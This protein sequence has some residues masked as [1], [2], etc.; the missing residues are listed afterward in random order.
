MAED[1]GIPQENEKEL[2]DSLEG[3]F[4]DWVNELEQAEQP[5]ACSI[6]NPECEACG[7]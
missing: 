2:F 7:S 5:K 6:D 4:A 3:D 1:Q